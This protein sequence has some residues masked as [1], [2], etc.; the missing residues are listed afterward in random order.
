M[1]SVTEYTILAKGNKQTMSLLT[2]LAKYRLNETEI[3]CI[4]FRYDIYSNDTA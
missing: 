4:C 2:Y 3:Y 1:A